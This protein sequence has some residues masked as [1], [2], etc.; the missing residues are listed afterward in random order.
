MAVMERA[1]VSPDLTS[2]DW[3]RVIVLRK[4]ASKDILR[5]EIKKKRR[6]R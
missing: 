1:M 6:P 4:I 5:R 3:R 2:M